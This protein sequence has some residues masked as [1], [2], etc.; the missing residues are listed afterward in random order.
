MTFVS[1]QGGETTLK[2]GYRQRPLCLESLE[3]WIGAFPQGLAA[4]HC[5]PHCVAA[6][7]P[8]FRCTNGVQGDFS[9]PP[10]VVPRP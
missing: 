5:C 4:L 2:G 1:Y 3:L 10:E 7:G 9:L 6:R 8:L